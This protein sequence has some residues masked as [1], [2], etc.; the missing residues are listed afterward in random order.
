MKWK[1][2]A[3]VALLT[4]S[5]AAAGAVP[6]FADAAGE[7]VVTS[8]D[9]IVAE[10]EEEPAAGDEADTR[11]GASAETRISGDMSVSDWKGYGFAAAVLLSALLLGSNVKDGDSKKRLS[12]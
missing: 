6:V 10:N 12:V 11:R 4:V 3:A 9:S 1:K 2:F 5:M 8:Y 7:S